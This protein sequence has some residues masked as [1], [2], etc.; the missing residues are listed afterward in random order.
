MFIREKPNKSGVVSVQIIDK[1]TGKY[2]VVKTVGSSKD[3]TQVSSLL[4]EAKN[5][6]A[7]LTGQGSLNFEIERE[8]ELVD[9]FFNGI[10]EIRLD[11]PELILGKLFDEIGFGKINSLFT[12]GQYHFLHLSFSNIQIPGQHET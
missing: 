11:G 7:N 3:P 8:Q 12:C 4:E 9:L 10:K 2:K 6:L 1:R 5:Q